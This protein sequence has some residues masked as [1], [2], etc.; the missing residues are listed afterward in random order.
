MVRRVSRK[1]KALKGSLEK[2]ATWDRKNKVKAKQ[3]LADTD[4]DIK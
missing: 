3:M 2:V 1:Q 4:D